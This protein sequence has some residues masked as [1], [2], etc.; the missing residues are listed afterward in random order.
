M[1]TQ[2]QV[3]EI[4]QIVN[5]ISFQGVQDDIAL[6]TDLAI[7]TVDYKGQPITNHSNCSDF[8]HLVRNSPS[9][10][11]CESCDSHGGL[12]AARLRKPC[13]YTCHAGL[14]DFA[15]PIL[16]N[17]LYLG[18]FMAGQVLL[19]PQDIDKGPRPILHNVKQTID[20]NQSDFREA[21]NSLPVMK[22]EKINRLANMLLHLGNYCI[23]EAELRELRSCHASNNEKLR[24]NN[25][26]YKNS[27]ENIIEP[28]LI[29]IQEN[30]SE[31]I[32]LS[33]MASLCNISPSYFSKLFAN[34]GLGSL[35]NYANKVKVNHAKELLITTDW[36]VISIAEAVGFND[37]GYF[38][39][40]FKSYTQQ[41]PIEYREDN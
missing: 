11:Y 41:T 21:Y 3:Y 24:T 17:D 9:A 6:A 1:K 38:I 23:K 14:I 30:P 27:T 32:T 7:I 40:V 36:P 20:M 35:S 2:L 16:A 28:A 22:W 29:Y 18:A 33:K 5:P 39:K 4:S 15:I 31:K 26:K 25:Y 12:E 34:E 19:S 10:V 13:I 37:C 8:C